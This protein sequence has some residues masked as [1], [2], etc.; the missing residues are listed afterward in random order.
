MLR[1]ALADFLGVIVSGFAAIIY[2]IAGLIPVAIVVVPLV[3]LILRWRRARGGKMFGRG[4]SPSPPAA[5][6]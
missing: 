4:K 3:W 2:L 5:N 6:T 1:N